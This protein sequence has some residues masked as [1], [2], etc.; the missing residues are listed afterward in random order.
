MNRLDAVTP[1]ELK[2]APRASDAELQSQELPSSSAAGKFVRVFLGYRRCRE[3]DERNGEGQDYAWLMADGSRVIGI[4]ADGV[5]QSFYGQIAA[6]HVVDGLAEHLREQAEFDDRHESRAKLLSALRKT[7]RD[8]A[9]E[10]A[11]YTLRAGLS[12]TMQEL[13]EQERLRGSQAVFGAFVYDCASQQL[14]ACQVGDVRLR[15]IGEQNGQIG[16]YLLPANKMGRY[17]TPVSADL[18]DSGLERDLVLQTFDSVLGVLLYSDGVADTWGQ[19]PAGL[20][21][22]SEGS[23]RDAMNVWAIKDDVSMVGLMTER[24]ARWSA[25]NSL[26]AP[27]PQREER[28]RITPIPGGSLAPPPA[29][30]LP[31]SPQNSASV[32]P[33]RSGETVNRPQL[34]HPAPMQERAPVAASKKAPEQ[35]S[36]H[37]IRR[38]AR[39]SALPASALALAL[40]SFAAGRFSVAAPKTGRKISAKPGVESAQPPIPRPIAG[41]QPHL[42]AEPFPIVPEAPDAMLRLDQVDKD[43]AQTVADY[44]ARLEELEKRVQVIAPPDP[45]ADA[46]S[47]EIENRLRIQ[48]R[49]VQNALKAARRAVRNAP[50]GDADGQRTNQ[51]ADA[52]TVG[53]SEEAAGGAVEPERRR[54][55]R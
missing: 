21:K 10:V 2:C 50:R 46:N 51:G 41:I 35:Q 20:E 42:P 13:L 16:S 38:I 19:R 11:A 49:A 36:K 34:A 37:G 53:Q 23:L 33:T 25:A 40:L 7:A 47:L 44:T 31:A 52:G 3:Y 27:E 43:L 5:S 39:M 30:P 1:V 24:V 45:D 8:G 17:C 29:A 22:G 15:I 18:Y 26:I 55:G 6:R 48:R 28:P 32:W 54:Q 9:Q 4:L 12:A 14:T